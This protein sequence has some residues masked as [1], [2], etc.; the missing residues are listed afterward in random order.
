MVIG[1][2][3]EFF[4][5]LSG[6]F[7]YYQTQDTYTACEMVHCEGN[8]SRAFSDWCVPCQLVIPRLLGWS[9]SYH[10]YDGTMLH[11]GGPSPRD[12]ED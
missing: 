11:W 9:Y 10:R 12:F 8:P 1:A 3:E 6:H 5:V 7:R 2:R 4:Q